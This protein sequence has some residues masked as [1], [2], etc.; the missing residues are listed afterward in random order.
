MLFHG[1]SRKGAARIL[2]EG[3]RN[4]ECGWFGKGV[5]MTDCSDTALMY[6]VIPSNSDCSETNYFIFVNE[7]LESE[8]LQTFEFNSSDEMKNIDTPLK[9]PFNKHINKSSPQATYENYKDDFVWRK[10]INIGHNKSSAFDEYVHGTGKGTSGILKEDFTNYKREWFGQ[11]LYMT[12][13][14]P[15]AVGTLVRVTSITL[16]T[17]TLFLSM[18]YFNQRSYT[19]LRLITLKSL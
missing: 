10:D 14:S 19:H 7:V 4:S 8:K 5:Y 15:T 6:S 16:E 17:I 3:Y 2:K 11:G 1:R 9:N 18:K 12:D 13:L